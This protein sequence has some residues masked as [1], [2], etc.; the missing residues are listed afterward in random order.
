VK[1]GWRSARGGGDA[2]SDNIHTNTIKYALTCVC[3]HICLQISRLAYLSTF[4]QILH[5]E[6]LGPD[7]GLTALENLYI[8]SIVSKVL[9]YEI[10]GGWRQ[11]VLRMLKTFMLLS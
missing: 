8:A 10:R 11:N 3:V 5:T 6:V 7:V 4:Q 1:T 2:A 9:S